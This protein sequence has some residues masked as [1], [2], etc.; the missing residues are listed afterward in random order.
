MQKI[1]SYL[2]PNRIILLADLAG[3][4]VEN[5][6]VYAK[7]VKIYKGVDNVIQFD[8]QNADQK[9]LDLVTNSP[10]TGIQMNVMDMSGK[11]LPTSPYMVHPLAPILASTSHAVI[12]PTTGQGTSTTISIPTSSITGAFAVGATI[13]ATGIVS[14]ITVTTAVSDIDSATTTLTVSF[15]PQTVLAQSSATIASVAE[16]L[17]GIA[18]VTIPY[19]DL[20]EIT[21]QN[22]KYS[23]TATD[24]FG[25]NIVLYTDSRFSAVGTME[26]VESAVPVCRKNTV[27]DR[28]SGEINFMG[29]VTNHTS[30]IPCKYYEAVP[31]ETLNFSIVLTNF[32]GTLFIEATTDSTISVESFRNAPKLQTYN[33]TVPVSTTITFTGVP[34]GKYNY[35]RVS[36]TYPDIWQYGSQ[37]DPTTMYGLVNSVTVSY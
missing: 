33:T 3:F 8:I 7:T 25:N 35:M 4:T 21:H 31:T 9:R 2:Y 20:E 13:T 24:A 15:L 14:P 32:I 11:A 34:V 27:Y 16:P 19:H 36:W 5:T 17:K 26:V 12:A 6:I 18:S 28:F 37:Q 1:Q 30:A 23:I 10:V 29:N 22:L